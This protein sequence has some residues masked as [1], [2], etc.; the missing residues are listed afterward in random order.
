MALRRGFLDLVH[1]VRGFDTQM[2]IMKDNSIVISSNRA[3][4]TNNYSEYGLTLALA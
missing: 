3:K 1:T 2:R 4:G